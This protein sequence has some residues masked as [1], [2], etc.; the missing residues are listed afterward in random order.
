VSTGVEDARPERLVL[1]LA[2]LEL[3]GRRSDADDVRRVNRQIV[4]LH[5]A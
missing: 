1:V 2:P 4:E 3:D 5:P